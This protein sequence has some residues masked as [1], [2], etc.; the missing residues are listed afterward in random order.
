MPESKKPQL[1]TRLSGR[2]VRRRR[3]PVVATTPTAVS[4]AIQQAVAQTIADLMDT[5]LA[6]HELA[7]LQLHTQLADIP[8]FTEAEIQQQEQL[9]AEAQ[10]SAQTMVFDPTV[11]VITELPHLEGEPDEFD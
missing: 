4:T 2:V 8:P 11:P 6:A 7:F 1:T 5:P 10:Q 9:F 3:N